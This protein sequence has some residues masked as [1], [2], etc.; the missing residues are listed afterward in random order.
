MS[1]SLRKIQGIVAGAALVLVGALAAG[2]GFRA[3]SVQVGV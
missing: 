1:I 2:T 3:D